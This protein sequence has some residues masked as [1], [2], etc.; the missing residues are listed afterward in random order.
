MKCTTRQMLDDS[1]AFRYAT[2]YVRGCRYQALRSL[3]KPSRRR[4]MLRRIYTWADVSRLAQLPTII[5]TITKCP[6]SDPTG[7]NRNTTT[8]NTL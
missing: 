1:R 5:K 3:T 8:N 7:H 2:P 4:A 6:V